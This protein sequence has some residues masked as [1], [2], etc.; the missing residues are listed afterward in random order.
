MQVWPEMV[1]L[2]LIEILLETGEIMDYFHVETYSG[3]CDA[4]DWIWVNSDLLKELKEKP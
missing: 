3:N 2:D 1:T 4:N